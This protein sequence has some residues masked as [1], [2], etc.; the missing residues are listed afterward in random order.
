MSS[1]GKTKKKKPPAIAARAALDEQAA[2]AARTAHDKKAGLDY[3]PPES[4][5]S[6]SE[7]E[8][9]DYSDDSRRDLGEAMGVEIQGVKNA[10][11][12]AMVGLSA[13]E[14]QGLLYHEKISKII[15][16]HREGL[17]PIPLSSTALAC[18][19]TLE[20]PVPPV[21]DS[22]R[23]PSLLASSGV[24][25]PLEM[26]ALFRLRQQLTAVFLLE[27]F[28]PLKQLTAVGDR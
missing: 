21:Q 18:E 9:E 28:R 25:Q 2:A 15:L 11:D 16:R 13:R 24:R 10:P 22:S 20:T 14:L 26:N 4:S 17:T 23:V 19:R 12:A 5:D 27:S 8:D 7:S 1:R 6:S 3:G